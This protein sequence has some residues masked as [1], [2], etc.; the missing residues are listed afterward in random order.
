[1]ST[2]NQI[3]HIAFCTGDMKEQ[4]QFYTSV[5]GMKLKALFWM[6][7]V[8]GAFHA[9][10]EL[11]PNCSMSFVY[12]PS[13]KEKDVVMGVSHVPNTISMSPGGTHQHIAFNM[14]NE[15]DLNAIV[16]R[17]RSHGYMISDPIDH[18][19]CK[20]VYM[21]APENVWIEFTITTRA[22][23]ERDIDKEVVGLCGI[24]EAELARMCEPDL[25]QVDEALL[26]SGDAQT[27]E[28][29]N[30]MKE[31]IK[32]MQAQG[33]KKFDTEYKHEV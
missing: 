15:E 21:L 11:N 6:H 4:L 5:I 33:Q 2:P 22:F 18:D 14:D 17:V 3:N 29:Q 23:D 28:M 32:Q 9:F 8:E 19:I 12:H 20:S 30:R 31:M 26:T 16:A 10:L 25:Q 7:G 27:K 13:I 1:M 24:S